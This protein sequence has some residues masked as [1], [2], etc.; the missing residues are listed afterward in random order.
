MISNSWHPHLCAVH[1]HWAW[2]R[3][4]SPRPINGIWPVQ[5]TVTSDIWLPKGCGFH[6]GYLRLLSLRVFA[7]G[8][9]G[10]YVWGALREV[11]HVKKLM[12]LANS[13]QGSEASREAELPPVQP[14]E[15]CSP[16]W[17]I[18]WS[19]V[20]RWSR[21]HPAGLCSDFWPTEIVR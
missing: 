17:H 4:I 9:V 20:R 14:G 21:G 6:V 16:G 8:E 15:D 2:A 1:S 10:C 5:W 13:Q 19:L 12:P 7:L 3:L 11:P 18:D